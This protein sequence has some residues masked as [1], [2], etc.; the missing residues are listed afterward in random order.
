MK[1]EISSATLEVY[2]LIHEIKSHLHDLHDLIEIIS[3]TVAKRPTF[4]YQKPEGSSGPA[5]N[6]WMR[7]CNNYTLCNGR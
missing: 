3:K 1:N 5:C 4:K 7:S 6:H 2:S